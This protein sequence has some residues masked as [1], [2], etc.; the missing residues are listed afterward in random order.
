[1]GATADYTDFKMENTPSVEQ[2]L[3]E[4]AASLYVDAKKY[5]E[6]LSLID[7]GLAKFP[8]SSKLSELKGTTYYKSGKMDQFLNNLKEQVAKDPNDKVSWYNLG[9]LSSKDPSKLAEAEGY[10]KKSLEIDPAYKEALQGI[11]FNVYISDDNKAIEA[12]ETA[13]KAKK[14]ELYNRLLS[15]RRERF[16]KALPYAEKWYALE[17]KNIEVVSLLKGL[18]LTSHNDAKFQELKA[19]EAALNAAG[20]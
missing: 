5:D 1:M 15:E 18:Y 7:K 12:I 4:T 19:V 10:F 14:T 9:V 2:E 17:P 13:R 3:Y 16:A 8:K 20:K 11:I 6:A